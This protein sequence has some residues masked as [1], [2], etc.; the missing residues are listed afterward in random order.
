MCEETQK[1]EEMVK[2]FLISSRKCRTVEMQNCCWLSSTYFQGCIDSLTDVL[3]EIG[4]IKDEAKR[5]NGR[6]VE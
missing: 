5:L 1:I 6:E 2:A 4:K 3:S